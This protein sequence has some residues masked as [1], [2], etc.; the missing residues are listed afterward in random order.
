MS[1]F[2]VIYKHPKFKELTLENFVEEHNETVMDNSAK[3][4]SF[5]DVTTKSLAE[6]LFA[7][8]YIT[9]NIRKT[10]RILQSKA[11][12]SVKEEYQ[13][14]LHEMIQQYDELSAYD[15]LAKHNLY[16]VDIK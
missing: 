10:E 9:Q 11:K 15:F 7:A 6:K 13:K 14:L 5:T 12:E 16:V 2:Y 3:L 1:N 8:E 4:K